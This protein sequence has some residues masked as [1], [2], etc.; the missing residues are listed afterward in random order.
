MKN[1]LAFRKLPLFWKLFLP[2]GF[3]TLIWISIII[4]AALIML[5]SRERSHKIYT[6]NI[7]LVLYLQTLGQDFSLLNQL[8]LQHV[9]SNDG[10]E[11]EVLNEKIQNQKQVVEEEF[12]RLEKY[13]LNDYRHSLPGFTDYHTDYHQ[14]MQTSSDILKLSEDFEKVAA[15]D[16]L[17]GMLSDNQQIIRQGIASKINSEYRFMQ[18]SYEQSRYILKKDI[19]IFTVTAG[20]AFLLTFLL[21]YRV[22]G[23]VTQRM[24]MVVDCANQLRQGDLSARVP[25]DVCEDEI[26]S[27]GHG[28]V[29]MAEEVRQ[30]TGLLRESEAQ[31]RILLD[32]MAEAIYGIDLAGNCTFVNK[33]CLQMLGYESTS[34]LL[35]ENIHD[36]IHH[37]YP[38]GSS[39]PVEECLVHQS[40]RTGQEVHNDTEVLWR[41]DGSS[42]NVE[43]R[44]HPIWKD[45][46]LTGVVVSF[47]DITKRKIAENNVQKNLDLLKD[48]QNIGHVGSW[49]W[50]IISNTIYWTD[51]TYRIFGFTPQEFVVTY[52]LFLNKI[53]PEDRVLVTHAVQEALDEK[54]PYSIQHRILLADGSERIVSEKGRISRDDAGTPI[55]M[56]GT[57]QDTTEAIKIETDLRTYQETLEVLVDERTEE[58]QKAKEEADQANQ[59][60]SVFLSSMSHE[61]RTPLNSVLGFGQLLYTDEKN[62]LTTEQKNQLGKIL[63]SGD[64]LL[65]LIDDVLNLSKIES[66]AVEISIESVNVYSVLNEILD[67]VEQAAKEAQVEIIWEEQDQHLFI[68]VDNTRFRQV[69]MNLLSNAIKYNFPEG[70]VHLVTRKREDKLR[71]TVVDTGIGISS[72]KTQF[73]FEP[74]N[75]LGAET[76]SIEGTGIGLTI[77]KRLVELMG[78]HIG[79]ESEVGKGTTFWVDFPI[80]QSQLGEDDSSFPQ[81]EK[82][83]SSLP[84]GKN[85][86]LLSIEDNK[87]NQDLLLA[88]LARSPNFHLLM[89]T[90]GAQG[91]DMAVQH[92]PDLI[93]L[94]IGLPDMDGFAVLNNLKQ[95]K[96]TEKIPVI[97][98]SGNAMPWDIQNALEEGFV[99]YLTKPLNIADLYRVVTATLIRSLPSS[100]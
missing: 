87:L 71:I 38:N 28:L 44:S 49:E 88:I 43:Y 66:G 47:L 22:I 52:D 96:E 13:I 21:L 91:V 25:Q 58:L 36:L 56:I 65:C 4:A 55:S 99:E 90:N 16:K 29:V 12:Q 69:I 60:K 98:L 19:L 95:Y 41:K 20:L 64:H 93:L 76:S 26:S 77:T 14:Y 37:S 92:K 50:D 30:T 42:F 74:F 68:D 24:S 18:S 40:V 51:E 53:H 39:Y 5:T 10:K 85:Y 48:S 97:A 1:K 8:V 9:A 79:Y 63:R 31:V 61:L 17:K 86:T 6:H 32:S 35:G 57:I 27:L 67:V 72:E 89:A 75:R 94:D 54:Q 33:S 3:A 2:V 45:G 7:T 80:A 23:R 70:T 78:C 81:T 46:K 62:P 15:F 100:R 11:I 34:D 84:D 59:A 82:V 73:L 83:M